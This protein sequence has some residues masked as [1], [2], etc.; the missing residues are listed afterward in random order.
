M[1]LVLPFLLLALAGPA[2]ADA[3]V[4]PGITL[5]TNATALSSATPSAQSSWVVTGNKWFVGFTVVAPVSGYAL[6]WDA[7]SVPADGAVTP[8]G[9]FPVQPPVAGGPNSFTSM[10]NTPAGVMVN[11]GI[12]IAFSTTGCFTK[13][14]SAAFIS[15]NYQNA[16]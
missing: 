6:I 11:N 3:L 12:A 5:V 8:G 16:P 4:P 1:R 15:I 9:C 13:T 2:T 14:S 7:T 10:A